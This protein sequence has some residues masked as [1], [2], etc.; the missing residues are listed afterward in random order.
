MLTQGIINHVG[1]VLDRSGS[2]QHLATEVVKVADG[3]VAHLATRSTDLDQETRATVYIFGTDVECVYYDKD[4]LRLPSLKDKYRI[5]G[6]TALI[7]ATMKAIEDLEKTATLYG[8]HA[9]LLYVLTDG[10]E[11]MSSKYRADHLTQKLRGL[12]D[13]WTVAAL[14]PN[15]S[16]LIYAQRVGFQSGNIA[17][18][19]TTIEGVKHVGATIQQAT[20]NFMQARAVG[21]R[22][23]KNIFNLDPA[24]VKINQ[25]TKLDPSQYTFIKVGDA[26]G[27]QIRDVVEGVTGTK[28]HKGDAYYQLTKTEEVQ[29]QKQLVIVDKATG[30]AYAGSQARQMLGLPH[31]YVKV[32]ATD[33]PKYDIFVQSTSVNR[34]LVPNTAV[35]VM[36]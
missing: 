2:M 21:I 8:D 22:G 35:L 19:D 15:E 36:S 3:Q 5:S 30:V 4:V 23:S 13:N 32:R 16:G 28:Y 6:S 10:M 17:R 24:N 12:P 27:Q 31:D 29:P 26:G 11:N 18:W 1:L 25:L 33:H 34:K 7:D 9:F 20:E 14:V